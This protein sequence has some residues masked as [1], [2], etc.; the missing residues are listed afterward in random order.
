MDLDGK[1][2]LQSQCFLTEDGSCGTHAL[3]VTGTENQE[4][5]HYPEISYPPSYPL[6]IPGGFFT[7][8]RDLRICK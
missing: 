1:C 4:L 5:A 2:I 7:I 3:L 8:S 6:G